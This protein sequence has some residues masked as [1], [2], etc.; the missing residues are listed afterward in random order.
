MAKSTLARGKYAKLRDRD[1]FHIMLNL[2]QYPDFLPTAWKLAR[3]FLETAAA[4]Q[5]DP[6]IDTELRPFRYEERAFDAR[7]DSIYQ[8]MV[9]RVAK[10]DPANDRAFRT[11]ADA[12]DRLR[13]S[14]P[15]NQ[16][17]G[18]WLRNVATIGPITDLTGFLTQIWV[19]EVGA[20]N[21]AQNHANIFTHTLADAGCR[22]VWSPQ[23]NLRLYGDTTLAAEAI[24]AGMPVALGADW[25]PSGATSLGFP[26]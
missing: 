8:D 6:M 23:S 14:G 13:Q 21:P 22:L 18:V 19:D 11:H 25:L 1:Y 9:D 4:Y 20:G 24:R 12:V 10:Y 16:T 5:H 3:D 7:L 15:L 17:D 2:H 26:S